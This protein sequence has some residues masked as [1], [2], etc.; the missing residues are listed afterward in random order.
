MRLVGVKSRIVPKAWPLIERWV[1]GAIKRGCSNDTLEKI[2]DGLGDA[3]MQLWLAWDDKTGR[4][5]GY[6][7]TELYEGGRG[8]TCN[9]V[10]CGGVAMR[11]WLPLFEGVKA[12]A[13]EA[14]CTRMEV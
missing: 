6:C 14:G 2:R 8:K 3:S 7:I 13:R 1:R 12:W 9:V 11:R 10:S 5:H 4:A